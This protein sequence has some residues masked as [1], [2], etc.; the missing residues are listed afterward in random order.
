[1]SRLARLLCAVLS[2]YLFTVAGPATAQMMIDVRGNGVDINNVG[3]SGLA[4]M[5]PIPDRLDWQQD[6]LIPGQYHLF[7]T[8]SDPIINRNYA[9]VPIPVGYHKTDTRLD[10]ALQ[11]FSANQTGKMLIAAPYRDSV[12]IGDWKRVPGVFSSTIQNFYLY[13][14]DYTQV[15][16]WVNIPQ[17]NPDLPTLFMGAEGANMRFANPLPISEQAEGRIITPNY[18]VLI[19]SPSLYIMPNGDY[20]AGA[21]G[22]EP[23]SGFTVRLWISKDKGDTWQA[24]NQ[25]P[26]D[27]KHQTHFY[28][29]GAMYVLGDI[30]ERAAI[31]KSTDGGKTWSSPVNLNLDFRTSP[32]HV[33]VSQGRLWCAT[34]V[35]T[36]ISA[37][38]DADL[39][40]P[41]SWTRAAMSGGS[42]VSGEPELTLTREGGLAV[43]GKGSGSSNS[44][45]NHVAHVINQNLVQAY[46]SEDPFVIP[47]SDSKYTIQY[48]PVSDKYWALTSYSPLP[49][50]IRTGIALWCADDLDSEFTFVKQVTQ[51]LSNQFQGFNYPYM[52]FDGD[53]IVFVSRTAWEDERGLARRWH[54]ANMMTFHRIPNFRSLI[55]PEPTSLSMLGAAWL[56]TCGRRPYTPTAR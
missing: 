40:N 52:Q 36:V 6:A 20:I 49:E 3:S 32:A 21:S 19:T 11:S 22:G 35:A 33:L 1:M 8:R 26:I 13:E 9:T 27:V 25:T 43:M 55:I 7:D 12:G 31:Q 30:N 50:N 44:A 28:H 10:Y 24:L 42:L 5:Y 38:V 47:V 54:D 53:D 29:N 17:P 2:L 18:N 23:R 39:M 46:S 37:P 51:G 14:Y 15:G 16:Q 45:S 56:L 4:H 41:A 34:E 48:D